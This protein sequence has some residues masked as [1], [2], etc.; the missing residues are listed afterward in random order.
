MTTAENS[1]SAERLSPAENLSVAFI[2]QAIDFLTGEYLPKIERCLERLTDEQIWWRSNE[3]C[4]SIGNLVLHLSGNARQ[5]I[6]CGLGSAPDTR[7]R[8]AEFTQREVLPRAELVDLLRS[9][10]A[11]VETTLR[12]LDP[13]TLLE[14]R[15]IQGSEVDVLHAIFHVT[16]HFSM[17]TGQIIMLTKMLAETDLRFYDFEDGAPVHRWLARPSGSS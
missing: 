5:W 7:T 14:K 3:D 4:N 8:D 10:I 13:S 2:N 16:E 17:H 9:T 11:D 6:V 1:L 15:T 12:Q